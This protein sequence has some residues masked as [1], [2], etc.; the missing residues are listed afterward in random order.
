MMPGKVA[1]VVIAHAV[2][3][4]APQLADAKAR[5]PQASTFTTQSPQILIVRS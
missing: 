1:R 5:W 2:A 4:E 3:L